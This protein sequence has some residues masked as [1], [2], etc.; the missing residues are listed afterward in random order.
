[1]FEELI[2]I[3]NFIIHYYYLFNSKYAENVKKSIESVLG[4]PADNKI[5]K[6]PTGQEFYNPY[7]FYKEDLDKIIS[8]TT[9]GAYFSYIHGD[10]NGANIIIDSHENV[11]IIDFFHTHRGHILKDLIKLENDLLYIFTNINS[12]DDLQDGIKLVNFICKVKDL[13]KKLLSIKD[14]N[15]NNPEFNRTYST[16]KY[17]RSFYSDLIKEDTEPLQL[18]IGLLRYSIH[19]LTFDEPNKYQKLLALYASGLYAN[20]IINLY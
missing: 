5:L 4:S 2:V 15:L 14:L 19:T 10:L 3:I 9:K 6:L 11:W 18:F 7:Y 12:L 17:L 8:K 1:M 20:K 16:L 13:S